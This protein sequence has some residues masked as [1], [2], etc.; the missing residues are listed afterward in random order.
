MT[1][2]TS[3]REDD[4]DVHVLAEGTNN[5]RNLVCELVGVGHEEGLRLLVCRVDVTEDGDSEGTGLS[6]SGLG[7]AEDI[8]ALDKRQDSNGLNGGGLL[9]AVTEDSAEEFFSET[10]FIKGL[11]RGELCGAGGFNFKLCVHR[12]RWVW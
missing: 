5:G 6:G 8:P 4:L 3:Y 7:L 12:T 2:Q 9:K 11:A 10:H 1:G